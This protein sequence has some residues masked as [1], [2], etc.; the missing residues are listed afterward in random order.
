M[1]DSKHTYDYFAN[2]SNCIR[3]IKTCG[4]DKSAT[5][6]NEIIIRII[7]K[8]NNTTHVPIYIVSRNAD[9]LRL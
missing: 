5:L 6:Y 1:I 2:M 9:K 7:D 4:G 8:A 3:D